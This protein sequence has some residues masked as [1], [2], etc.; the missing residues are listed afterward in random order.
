MPHI[1]PSTGTSHGCMPNLLYFLFTHYCVAQ[2]SSNSFH[3]FTDTTTIVGF[4]SDA[5]KTTCQEEVGVYVN[6]C[7]VLVSGATISIQYTVFQALT[8]ANLLLYLYCHYYPG[9]HTFK[10]SKHYI[11]YLFL[12][13]NL[14]T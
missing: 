9:L 10:L 12:T 11:I 6:L 8:V 2:N 13:L 1:L 14:G 3:K 5:D 4:I 7:P